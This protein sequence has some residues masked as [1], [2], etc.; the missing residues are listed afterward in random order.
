MYRS[1]LLGVHILNIYSC[2]VPIL[3]KWS[4]KNP[5]PASFV[6]ISQKS[7]ILT[8]GGKG[9]FPVTN[10]PAGWLTKQTFRSEVRRKGCCKASEA[11]GLKTGSTWSIKDLVW[12]SCIPWRIAHLD[13]PVK[14]Y[15]TYT[16]YQMEMS[17]WSCSK[18]NWMYCRFGMQTCPKHT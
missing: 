10:V 5:K 8:R 12:K 7:P 9:D 6:G 15:I 3:G 14:L 17:L 1:L 16:P 13:S 18:F 11:V 2:F 4:L